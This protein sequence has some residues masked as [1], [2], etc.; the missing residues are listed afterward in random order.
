M[1]N[2][3]PSAF[4]IEKGIPLP[5]PDYRKGGRRAQYPWHLLDVG[6]SVLFPTPGTARVA[7]A[8]AT[9][10]GRRFVISKQ[11]HRPFGYRIWRVA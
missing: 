7:T 10:N 4:A 11:R 8:W 6:D 1:T 5:P 2:S 3:I 9:R